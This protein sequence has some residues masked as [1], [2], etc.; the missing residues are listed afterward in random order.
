MCTVL[1]PLGVRDEQY[2]HRCIPQGVV[3]SPL[4]TSG[5][6]SHRWV[7]PGC[8]SSLTV[9]LFPGRNLLVYACNPATERGCAQ[10]RAEH[11]R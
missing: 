11:E 5:W 7:I 2:V 8:D 3:L 10:G 1:A 6:S 9:G 4:Y